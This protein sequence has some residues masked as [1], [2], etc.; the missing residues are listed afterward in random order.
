MSY[1]PKPGVTRLLDSYHLRPS[2]TS[3]HRPRNS[4]VIPPKFHET[5]SQWH[6]PS[7]THTTPAPAS[8]PHPPTA[9]PKIAHPV[10]N[11]HKTQTRRRQK[12][13]STPAPHVRTFLS[14]R[15]NTSSTAQSATRYDVRAVSQRKL[16]AGTVPHACSKCRHRLYDQK[17][18]GVRGVVITALC[19]R[20]F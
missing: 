10:R 17:G 1:D 11:N 5:L 4:A 20:A 14:S 19:A 7:P 2:P 16:Y 9:S 12:R 6:S 13:H 8:I 18:T 15:S 3:E